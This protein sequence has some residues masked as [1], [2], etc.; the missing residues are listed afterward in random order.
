MISVRNLLFCML[1]EEYYKL[2]ILIIKN[3]QAAQKTDFDSD[4][5]LFVV[6][7]GHRLKINCHDLLAQ[8][9]YQLSVV[10]ASEADYPRFKPTARKRA[11]NEYVDIAPSNATNGQ[12]EKDLFRT[13]I[14]NKLTKLS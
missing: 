13:G 10:N 14:L 5:F 12:M 4:S 11:E 6:L 8:I 3:F 9:D 1:Y 7:N 2:L